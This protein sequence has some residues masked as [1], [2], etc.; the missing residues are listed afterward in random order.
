MAILPRKYL[1]AGLVLAILN[2]IRGLV[3][4][5][6]LIASGAVGQVL[7]AVLRSGGHG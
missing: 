5:A 2:E 4:V 6:G 1:T 3:F 7:H